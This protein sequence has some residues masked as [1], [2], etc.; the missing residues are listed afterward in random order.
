M[1][2][3]CLKSLYTCIMVFQ[4]H[5]QTLSNNVVLGG[6][7]STQTKIKIINEVVLIAAEP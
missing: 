4:N 1:A 2:Y 5:C 7:T 6:G 3:G